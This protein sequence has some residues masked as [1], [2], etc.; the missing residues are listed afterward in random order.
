MLIELFI[1]FQIL[2]IG[3]FITAFFTK[4]E[5]L[6]GVSLIISA[7]LM[8]TSFNVEYFAYEPNL[9]TGI[10]NPIFISSSYPYLMGLNLLFFGL[11]ITFSLFDMFDKYGTRN[12]SF[13]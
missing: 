8:Y 4:Q 9:T 11:S 13:R 1:L 12:E 2:G 7:V 6:W 10:Y 3:F 5:V